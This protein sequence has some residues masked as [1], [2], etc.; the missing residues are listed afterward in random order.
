MK[1][2]Y[3]ILMNKNFLK[4]LFGIFALGWLVGLIIAINK[5]IEKCVC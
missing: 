4:I 3:R 1:I 5:V 2:I